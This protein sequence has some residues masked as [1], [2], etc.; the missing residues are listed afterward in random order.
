MNY[1]ARLHA[2]KAEKCLT[3]ELTKPTK[4]PNDSS[5]GVL[6]VLAVTPIGPFPELMRLLPT[7]AHGLPRWSHS[8]PAARQMGSRRT[9]GQ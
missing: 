6:A 2:L 4:P 7:P 9:Y 5:G 1:L 3:V 8:I